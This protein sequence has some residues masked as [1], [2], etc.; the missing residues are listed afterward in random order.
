MAQLQASA[1]DA[2]G[3]RDAIGTYLD[4]FVPALT[5]SEVPAGSGGD[6]AVEPPDLDVVAGESNG[7]DEI[8]LEP[9]AAEPDPS[10]TPDEPE[11]A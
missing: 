3:Q 2:Q 11:A 4:Q 10:S 6:S 8:G 1:A 9:G 5:N 7:A